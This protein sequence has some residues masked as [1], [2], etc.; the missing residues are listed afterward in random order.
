MLAMA[1]QRESLFSE[2]WCGFFVGRFP[3]EREES[4]YKPKVYLE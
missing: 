2:A 1:F 4:P 3:V